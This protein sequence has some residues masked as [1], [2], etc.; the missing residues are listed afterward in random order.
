MTPEEFAQEIERLIQSAVDQMDMAVDAA[1]VD[2]IESLVDET[3][4]LGLDSA[5]NI[6]PNVGNLNKR[7]SIQNKLNRILFGGQFKKGLS[8]VTA[9]MRKIASTITK[10]LKQF[11][12]FKRPKSF[13]AILASAIDSV[14]AALGESG[15]GATVTAQVDELIRSA[16]VGGNSIQSL[17]K[18]MRDYFKNRGLGQVGRINANTLISD[19]MTSLHGAMMKQEAGRLGMKWFKYQGGLIDTTRS[20]CRAR[21]GH[22]FHQ[23]EIESWASLEWDGKNPSTTS[24][25]IFLWKGGYNCRHFLIPVVYAVVPAED[26]ARFARSQR[27]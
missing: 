25:T 11:P 7:A 16:I 23:K 9:I 24:A 8:A 10:Y 6:K 4:N 3:A 22:Y 26:R 21:N 1:Q 19:A 17:R 15:I 18:A 20:F 13:D 14:I 12:G 5:G 2:A 27:N